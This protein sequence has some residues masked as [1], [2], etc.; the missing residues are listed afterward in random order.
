MASRLENL[1]PSVV[2]G[3]RNSSST[4]AAPSLSLFLY[5]IEAWRLLSPSC[6]TLSNTPKNHPKNTKPYPLLNQDKKVGK[7]IILLYKTF[8]SQPK[9][10]LP[11]HIPNKIQRKMVHT[12]GLISG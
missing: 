10:K 1:S 4:V 9:N 6:N 3:S 5:G 7:S 12:L 8:Y 2:Q 11:L